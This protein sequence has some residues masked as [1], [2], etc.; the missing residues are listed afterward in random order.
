MTDRS[1]PIDAKPERYL[2]PLSAESSGTAPGRGRLKGRP[3]AVD[4]GLSGM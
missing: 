2:C 3:L 1:A 4:S